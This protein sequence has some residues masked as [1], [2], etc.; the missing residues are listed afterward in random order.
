MHVRIA[1]RGLRP[2]TPAWGHSI[3]YFITQCFLK[4][5]L[6]SALYDS[7]G[8]YLLSLEVCSLFNGPNMCLY[9]PMESNIQFT[10]HFATAVSLWSFCFVLKFHKSNVNMS[11]FQSKNNRFK[12][13]KLSFFTV[14]PGVPY[15]LSG[16]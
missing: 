3:C 12:T 9:S 10:E 7:P 15:K 16:W 11:N 13:W 8:M 4:Y 14:F 1:R 2:Q 6:Y 5:F